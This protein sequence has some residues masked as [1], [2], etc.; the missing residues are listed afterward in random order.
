MCVFLARDQL[1][2]GNRQSNLIPNEVM[3]MA[4]CIGESEEWM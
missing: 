3:R 4:S 1:Q 2:S